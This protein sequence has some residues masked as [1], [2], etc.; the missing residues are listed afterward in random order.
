VM[1]TSRRDF[2]LLA[3]AAAAVLRGED[4]PKRDMVVRSVRPED[5]ERSGA[6]LSSGGIFVRVYVPRWMRPVASESAN[7]YSMLTL[8]MDDL[9][10]CRPWNSSVF[11]N[12]RGTDGRLQPPVPG[13]RGVGAVSN[14]MAWSSSDAQT[15]RVKSIRT[16]NSF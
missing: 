12:A 16:R 3:T 4:R 15:C 11:S 10:S 6:R 14:A 13:L 7:R 2:L 9:K 1:R 8:T 5:L